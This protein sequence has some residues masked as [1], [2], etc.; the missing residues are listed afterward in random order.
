MRRVY[1]GPKLA[2]IDPTV[3]RSIASSWEGT[4][5]SAGAVSVDTARGHNP[6]YG[7]RAHE[8]PGAQRDPRVRRGARAGGTRAAPPLRRRADLLHR[9]GG[10]DRAGVRR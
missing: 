2:A 6:M 8:A 7:G 4:S 10:A 1:S 5:D 3:S 9:A